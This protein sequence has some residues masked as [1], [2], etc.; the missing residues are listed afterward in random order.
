MPSER[1]VVPVL[2][3]ALASCSAPAQ[4]PAAPALAPPPPA[5]P[6][7]TASEPSSPE[8]VGVLRFESGRGY[9]VARERAERVWL[10]ISENKVLVRQLQELTDHRVSASGR[11]G[12]M[13]AGSGASVPDGE[14]YLENITV[15]PAA[16]E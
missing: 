8:I 7:G 16:T 1:W 3:A 14:L 10:W 4:P 13:P 9:F 2:L 12:R 15:E 5:A 6:A 11:L